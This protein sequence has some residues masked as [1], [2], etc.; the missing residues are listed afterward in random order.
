MFLLCYN[1]SAAS[2]VRCATL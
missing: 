1:S 2:E